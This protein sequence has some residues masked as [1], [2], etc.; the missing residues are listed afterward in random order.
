MGLSASALTVSVRQSGAIRY[1]P[2]PSSVYVA[3]KQS[4]RCIGDTARLSG[5]VRPVPGSNSWFNQPLRLVG[6]DVA[7]LLAA[8]KDHFLLSTSKNPDFHP[9]VGIAIMLERV[10][11][12]RFELAKHCAVISGCIRGLRS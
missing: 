10:A 4:A 3:S 8:V 5:Q 2:T 12:Q 6:D 11:I 1:G 9:D 7:I